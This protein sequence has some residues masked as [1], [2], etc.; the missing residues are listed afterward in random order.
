LTDNLTQLVAP[1]DPATPLATVFKNADA[2]QYFAEEG[3][4]P[5]TDAAYIRNTLIVFTN[6]GVFRDVIVGWHTKPLAERTMANLIAHFILLDKIR[7][8]NDRPLKDA[9]SANAAKTSTPV[10]I[11]ATTPKPSHPFPFTGGTDLNTWGYC[12]NHGFGPDGAHTS[13]TCARPFRGHCREATVGNRMGGI[14]KLIGKKGDKPPFRPPPRAPT[15][16]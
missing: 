11:P 12:W 15:Q 13:A 4:K 9:L 7:R 2:Y 16:G 8:V 6:S 1:W 5:I 3:G 10:S 14:A